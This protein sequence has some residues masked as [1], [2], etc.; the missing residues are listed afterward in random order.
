MI[1][2]SLFKAAFEAVEKIPDDNRRGR[3]LRRAHS[4]S[5]E[6]LMSRP[7]EVTPESK[8]GPAG[9]GLQPLITHDFE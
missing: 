3:M 4:G 7:D 8:T 5:Y 9:P 1:A 2:E 6:R